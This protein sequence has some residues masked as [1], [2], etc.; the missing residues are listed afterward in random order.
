MNM[1][2][3]FVSISDVTTQ[4]SPI[5]ESPE[6]ES[7][8]TVNEP[9]STYFENKYTEDY[10]ED[11]KDSEIVSGFDKEAAVF[12]NKLAFDFKHGHE[13]KIRDSPLARHTPK[14]LNHPIKG[15]VKF[16]PITFIANTSLHCL[17]PYSDDSSSDESE[18]DA[19]PVT[20]V[21]VPSGSGSSSKEKQHSKCNEPIKRVPAGR[22]A[23]DDLPSPFTTPKSKA[24]CI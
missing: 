19:A 8:A 12:V 13:L 21:P 11:K 3:N 9:G 24:K 20:Q 18:A 2:Y 6:L 22:K 7:P 23:H 17:G 4:L 14:I 15:K 16:A 10:E 5:Y 1:K